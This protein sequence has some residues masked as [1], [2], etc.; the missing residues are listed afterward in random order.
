MKKIKVALVY[1]RVNSWGGAERVLLVL[2]E[3][4][5]DAPLYTSL[6]HPGKASWAKVFPKV[7]TSFLNKFTFFQD[8]HRYLAPFMPFAFETFKFDEYDLVISLTS[9]YAKGIITRPGTFHI[10]IILTPT[11]YLWSHYDFYFRNGLLKFLSKPLVSYLKFWD[12]VASQR[13]DVLVAISSE[14]KRRIKK[15]YS[16]DS[17]LI[18]P[19]VDLQKF[20]T[21]ELAFENKKIN[22]GEYFLFVSRPAGYKRLDLVIEVFNQTGEELV[23]LGGD[24]KSFRKKAKENIHFLGFVDDES[25]VSYYQNA[26][27]LIFPSYEDFGM[28]MVEANAAGLPIIA[29]AKGGAR[30]IVNDKTGIL[31]NE[32]SVSS[33]KRALVRFKRRKFNKKDLIENA[34]RFSKETFKKKFLELIDRYLLRYNKV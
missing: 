14:V 1:D 9:E 11:R 12:K 8:K 27:A 23:V 31:F 30:D 32:Q 33:I 5:P 7:Y 21:R 4:F 17:E 13:P 16:R 6:Y 3:I 2:N 20:F 24:Y 22:K 34:K 19:P 15:Y 26:K 28:V 10:S 29:Y 18:Y 25:L